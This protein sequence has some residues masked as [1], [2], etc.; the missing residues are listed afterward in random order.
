MVAEELQGDGDR[1]ASRGPFSL[2]KSSIARSTAPSPG[3]TLVSFRP[4]FPSAW[5]SVEAGRWRGSSKGTRNEGTAACVRFGGQMWADR[6]ILPCPRRA[7]FGFFKD[8]AR[9]LVCGGAFAV[10]YFP[11]T[12]PR[13]VK[14]R[15]HIPQTAAPY[16]ILGIPLP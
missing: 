14:I 4:S 7:M 3:G 5:A 10:P 1:E 16:T 11:W 9:L 6:A 8:G 15:D 12:S 2:P 13:Q